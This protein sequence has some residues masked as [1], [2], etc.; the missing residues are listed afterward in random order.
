MKGLASVL[1]IMLLATAAAV[2][3]PLEL[4][5]GGGPSATSLDDINASISVF[6][7][8]INHLN[9]TFADHPDVSGTVGTLSPIVSGLSMHASERY[10]LADWIAVGAGVEYTRSGAS[11]YGTYEGSE[12]STIDLSLAS[13]TLGVLVGSRIR[14]LNMGLLLAADLAAGFYHSILDHT[15]VFEIPEEYP[16]AISGVPPESAGRST[17]NT[18]GVEA[19]FSLAYPIAEWV[20]VGALLS[21]R[22]ATIPALKGED[23]QPFDLDGNGVP[24]AI[25][26]DGITVQFTFSI[27]VDLSLDGGKE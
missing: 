21:Y 18:F 2:A 11:T 12:T 19:G 6:N 7:T 4:S 13:Q 20:T 9:E 15:V 10:W 14:F 16:D 5:I 26:L 22:S 17:G 8:L 27:R 25:N 24:E 23:G 1:C 3:G